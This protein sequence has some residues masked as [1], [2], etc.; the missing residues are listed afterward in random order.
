MIAEM[1]REFERWVTYQRVTVDGP[2][3]RRSF[4]SKDG[5]WT[6]HVR[7]PA[8]PMPELA[9]GDTLLTDAALGVEDMTRLRGRGAYWLDL[10]GKSRSEGGSP[11]T[12][13]LA[14]FLGRYGIRL[15]RA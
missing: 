11:L 2:P 1:L 6:L 10:R 7:G 4:R 13:E 5:S 3:T 12:E 9:R 8:D 14:T 15:P